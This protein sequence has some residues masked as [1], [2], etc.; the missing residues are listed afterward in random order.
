MQPCS[1]YCSPDDTRIMPDTDSEYNCDSCNLRIN[2]YV[3]GCSKSG[4]SMGISR[5]IPEGE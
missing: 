4:F 1:K 2:N 5:E 3:P